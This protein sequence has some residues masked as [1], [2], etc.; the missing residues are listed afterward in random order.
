MSDIFLFTISHDPSVG[1]TNLLYQ[2]ISFYK[3]GVGAG[4]DYVHTPFKSKRSPSEVFRFLGFNQ[5]WP[6][7]ISQPKFK[8]LKVIEI[9]LG[10]ERLAR[11]NI[12]TF[13]LL[14]AHIRRKVLETS[15]ATAI[16]VIIAFTLEGGRDFFRT[17][18]QSSV[19]DRPAEYPVQAA[20]EAVQQRSRMWTYEQDGSRS[21]RILFHIRQGDTATIQTPWGSY[22][23]LRPFS[24]HRYKE[25]QH[26]GGVEIYIPPQSFLFFLNS[27]HKQL[28]SGSY[29][30]CVFSDGYKAGFADIYAHWKRFRFSLKQWI[31][32]K[33]CEINY[34]QK[35]FAEFKNVSRT[36]C[37][38]GES[39]SKLYD[40]IQAC[41]TAD[42]IVMGTQQRMLLKLLTLYYDVSHPKIVFVLNPEEQVEDYAVNYSLPQ[43]ALKVIHVPIRSYQFSDLWPVLSEAAKRYNMPLVSR[44]QSSEV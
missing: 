13:D 37:V 30:T 31:R 8:H 36:R 27:L 44:I 9:V 7:L 3:L 17:M 5:A 33:L 22:I 20:Y 42:I 34:D 40:L 14:K 21:L 25:I 32:L 2:F 23:P 26:P 6:N 11:E 4:G 29:S 19:P 43:E 28:R 10:D 24:K 38:I 15:K 18:I 39:E 16:P 1:L 12:Q 35:M 41:L